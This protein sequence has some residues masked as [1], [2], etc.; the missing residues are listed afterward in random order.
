MPADLHRAAHQVWFIRWFA[1]SFH[2]LAP[3]P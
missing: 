3:T 2:T 1:C